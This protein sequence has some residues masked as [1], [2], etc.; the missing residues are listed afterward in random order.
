VALVDHLSGVL[1]VTIVFNDVT[2]HDDRPTGAILMME[3][4]TA[5]G[6]GAARDGLPRA[7]G[8]GAA[9]DGAVGADGH[10]ENRR[11]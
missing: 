1:G 8:D 5:D 4:T 3:E 10:V 2:N 9:G 6:D 7:A 11:H